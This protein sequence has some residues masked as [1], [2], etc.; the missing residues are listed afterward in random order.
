MPRGFSFAVSLFLLP[1]YVRWP[2]TVTTKEITSPQKKKTHDKRKN[3]KAK[4]KDS[5]L[6]K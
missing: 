6:K 4:V 1:Q 3:L 2:T 5:Q